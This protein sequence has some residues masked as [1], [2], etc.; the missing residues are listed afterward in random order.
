MSTARL[1]SAVFVIFSDSMN[2][3][4]LC[5]E[6][7]FISLSLDIVQRCNPYEIFH[8]QDTTIIQFHD[9]IY[10]R[11]QIFGVPVYGYNN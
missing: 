1:S 8:N 11:G 3:S 7:I 9:L 5:R 2:S 6:I 4:S 10:V